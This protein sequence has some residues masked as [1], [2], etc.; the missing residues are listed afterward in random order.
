VAALGGL[1]PRYN[2]KLHA[3]ALHQKTKW[4]QL[5]TKMAP[6]QDR[7]SAPNWSCQTGSVVGTV[8]DVA[9]HG[10]VVLATFGVLLSPWLLAKI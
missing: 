10:G 3:L 2:L 4:L 5:N 8:R 9:S 6:T 7:A 1:A